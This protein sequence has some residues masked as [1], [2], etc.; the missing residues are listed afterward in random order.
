MTWFDRKVRV[1]RIRRVRVESPHGNGERLADWADTDYPPEAIVVEQAC[2][3][4]SSTS[5]V[6]SLGRVKVDTGM[7]LYCPIMVD[8]KPGD[9]IVE[10]DGR[11]WDVI[12]DNA[13]YVNPFTNDCTFGYDTGCEIKL[14]LHKG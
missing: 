5:E 2:V 13:S 3:A 14:Q 9:R 6:S 7:S 10:G 12:G 11:V 1:T 4:P 8:V